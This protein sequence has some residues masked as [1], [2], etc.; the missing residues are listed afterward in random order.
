V[1]SALRRLRVRA[2]RA[3]RRRARSSAQRDHIL[4]VGLGLDPSGAEARP[5]R[6]DRVVVD[7]AGLEEWMPGGFREAEVA[8]AIAVQV[9]DLT[10]ADLERELSAPTRGRP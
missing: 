10:A 6:E 7:P 8:R 5:A 1:A 4:D 3:W 9:A 2:S